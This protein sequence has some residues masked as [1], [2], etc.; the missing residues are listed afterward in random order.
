MSHTCTVLLEEAI[1]QKLH[2]QHAVML[3]P[4]VEQAVHKEIRAI[5]NRLAL[6]LAR[7]V[8]ENGQTKRLVVHVLRR[9]GVNQTMLKA[10]LDEASS[11]ARL[12]LLRKSP[13]LETVLADVE[14][15]LAENEKSENEKKEG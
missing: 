13:Q 15:W 1:R 6:L 11:A 4:I 14:A 7:G 2:I 5:S 3:Q 8:Y 9:Y 10:M 12:T